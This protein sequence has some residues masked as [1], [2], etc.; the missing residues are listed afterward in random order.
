MTPSRKS[1]TV[2]DR[3]AIGYP[4]SGTGGAMAVAM[5]VLEDPSRPH[6]CKVIYEHSRTGAWVARKRILGI[7]REMGL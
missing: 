2:G 4:P 3:V 1:Y 5:I 7:A 6:V